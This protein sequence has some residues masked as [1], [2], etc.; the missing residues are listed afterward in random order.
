[1]PSPASHDSPHAAPFTGVPWWRHRRGRR[2]R[3]GLS[4]GRVGGGRGRGRGCR[5]AHHRGTG[6]PNQQPQRQQRENVRGWFHRRCPER[7]E[8]RTTLSHATRRAVIRIV[9]RR[10]RRGLRR[11]RL[12]RRRLRRGRL[13]GSGLG[14]F[15][16]GGLDDSRLRGRTG[17]RRIRSGGCHRETQRQQHQDGGGGFHVT[18]DAPFNCRFP[19]Q[20]A[21]PVVSLSSP[22]LPL[23]QPPLPAAPHGSSRCA[24]RG[25]ERRPHHRRR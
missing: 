17:L 10:R 16:R 13:G 23:P 24:P 22:R 4:R 25:P 20:S 8:C 12:L 6:G 11:G 9:H 14:G 2:D 7:V 18:L 3:R 15:R 19:S 5:F 1:M 21:E